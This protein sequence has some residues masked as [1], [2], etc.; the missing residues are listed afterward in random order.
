ML[1]EWMLDPAATYLNHGTVGAT[2]RRVLAAQQAIRDEIEA[3]PARF[4]LR[5]LADISGSGQRLR[6]RAAADAAASLIAAAADDVVFVDNATTAANSV[7]RSFPFARRGRDPRQLARLR[8]GHQRGSIRRAPR[9]RDR[10]RG[11]PAVAARGP[12]RLRGCG[13]SCALSGHADRVDRSRHVAHRA[14][15]PRRRD[16]RA[17]PRPRRARARR[18]RARPRRLPRRRAGARRGLVVRQPAQ[19]GVGAAQQRHPVDLAGAAG[20]PPPGGRVVGVRPRAR[21]RVRP[22][23]HP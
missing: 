6:M 12:A 13:G 8:R 9:G 19:V 14:R 7:L 18:R 3:Q 17:M 22:A 15:A 21:R 20:A 2:P 23:R 5:E 1:S 11:G 16:R 10:A 4:L